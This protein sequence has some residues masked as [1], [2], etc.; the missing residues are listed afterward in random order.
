MVG[1]Y[2]FYRKYKKRIFLATSLVTVGYFVYNYINS[3]RQELAAYQKKLIKEKIKKKY[4]HTQQDCLFTIIALL[5]T[6]LSNVYKSIPVE[7]ITKQ[8]LT[9]RK[10][11]GTTVSSSEVES[12]DPDISK[13]Q[14]WNDLK[15]KSLTRLL[16]LIYCSSALVI[17]VKLQLNILARKGY[18][19]LSIEASGVAAPSAESDDYEAEQSYLSVSWWLL[20]RGYLII[21]E[22][23]KD[24]IELVFRDINPKTEL[25]F[26]EFSALIAKTQELIDK[27]LIFNDNFE[28]SLLPL[29]LH[30]VEL[31]NRDEILTNETFGSLIEETKD[32]LNNE[33]INLVI[34]TMVTSSISIL[35]EKSSTLL[36]DQEVE[37]IELITKRFKLVKLLSIVIKETNKIGEGSNNNLYVQA[38]GNLPELDEYAASVYSNFA[39]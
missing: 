30:E 7:N 31:L 20:N 33:L 10:E 21:Q 9:K 8:L 3:K 38:V 28:K 19:E 26:N 2:E 22:K 14:L 11:G 4:Q 13:A 32:Y 35:L 18:L 1:I 16:T 6:L 37:E 25:T 15:I 23:C 34:V 12:S 24:A 5:P 29:E 36:F 39:I 17:L 27:S